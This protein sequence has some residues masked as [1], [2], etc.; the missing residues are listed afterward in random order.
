MV[1]RQG[2]GLNQETGFAND[3]QIVKICDSIPGILG[4]VESK[5]KCPKSSF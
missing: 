5:V 1:S 4:L 3:R 2:L